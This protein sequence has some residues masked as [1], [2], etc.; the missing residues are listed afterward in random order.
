MLHLFINFTNS[1]K[2]VQCNVTYIGVSLSTQN[3]GSKGPAVF[4]KVVPFILMTKGLFQ[5]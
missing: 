5:V 4:K 2:E 3:T 1:G